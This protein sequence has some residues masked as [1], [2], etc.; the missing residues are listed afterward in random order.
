MREK[1]HPRDADEPQRHREHDDE[2]IEERAELYDHD[3]IDEDHGEQETKAERLERFLHR[4]YFAAHLN[5]IAFGN[6]RA[7]VLYLVDV[8]LDVV[9]DRADIASAHVHENV[10]YTRDI[11]MIDL[12]IGRAA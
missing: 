5:V 6:L 8:T 2:R 1:E 7:V 4:L 10:G 11:E 9:G 3:E 12:G